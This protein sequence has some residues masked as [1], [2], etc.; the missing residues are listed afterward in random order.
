[1]YWVD[2]D[3]MGSGDPPIFVY[4]D[5]TTGT[6]VVSHDSE[7]LIEVDPCP[8]PGCSARVI[9][10]NATLRQLVAL[11]E[12][13]HY[14]QQFIQFDCFGVPLEYDRVAQ[15]WWSDR[16]GHPQFYWAG[17]NNTKHTCQCGMENACD[18]PSMTCNCNSLADVEL[19]DQGT[20][21]IWDN[22]HKFNFV[23]GDLLLAGFITNKEAL[24][25]TKLNVGGI[26]DHRSYGRY[27]LGKLECSGREHV[28]GIPESCS[29]LW[30]MGHTLN[31][32][33]DVKRVNEIVKVYC[34]FTQVPGV[35]GTL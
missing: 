7:F 31:G 24:P 17:E 30:K 10:Y 4:C 13:S 32:F 18:D 23:F 22:L 9:N 5:M 14:C 34:D 26:T 11:T 21:V 35:K 28:N 19:S 33:Y 29:D 1:M 27:I 2:P 12:M 16:S 20:A 6:T 25:V 8:D 15:F 3:G